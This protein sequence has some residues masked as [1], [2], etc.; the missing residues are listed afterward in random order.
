M[1]G[2]AGILA[3]HHD[4]GVYRWHAAFPAEEVG[5]AVEHAG[6]R[7]GYVDGWHHQT[8]A[9]FLAAVGEAL[10]FPEYYGRNLDALNDCLGDV[11]CYGPYD[12]SPEGSGLV[13]VMTD[14]DRFATASPR[15]AQ[16]VLDIIAD[17]ARQAAVLQR[18][19]F[20][21]IHSNDPDIRFE[22][23]GATAV[24][25]NSEEWLDSRRR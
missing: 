5:H 4:P 13:L 19:F 23:V 11:A 2:L 3:H 21:L 20:A 12:D 8:R 1:S 17:R 7:F 22:P 18:R 9:E 10:S 25:W 16:I 6:W 14:Y 24:M 15:T